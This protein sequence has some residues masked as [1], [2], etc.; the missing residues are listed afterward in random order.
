MLTSE[1]S[2]ATA[3][4]T[5]KNRFG[6]RIASVIHLAAYFDFTGEDNPLYFANARRDRSFMLAVSKAALLARRAC[7]YPSCDRWTEC[8][9]WLFRT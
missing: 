1:Q 6:G 4:G 5:I 8:V 3:I 2:I 9:S 7:L